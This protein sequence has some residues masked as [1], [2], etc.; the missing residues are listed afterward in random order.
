MAIISPSSW[1]CII[2]Q[3]QYS[4]APQPNNPILRVYFKNVIQICLYSKFNHN[5]G[6]I[7]PKQMY[8]SKNEIILVTGHFCPLRMFNFAISY[9]IR[10]SSI[11]F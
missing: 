3:R 9:M 4:K 2:Y 5:D 11:L 7:Q 8:V 6:S 10:F 1:L